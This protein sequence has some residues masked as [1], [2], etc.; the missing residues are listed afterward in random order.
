MQSPLVLHP[1]LHTVV[2]FLLFT[3]SPHGLVGEAIVGKDLSLPPCSL[4]RHHLILS[5]L[6]MN[7]G[8]FWLIIILSKYVHFVSLP[9]G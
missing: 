1:D 6:L 2:S 9:Y 3:V 4:L 7:F 8:F 5:Y